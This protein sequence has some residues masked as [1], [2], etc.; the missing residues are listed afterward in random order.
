MEA[1]ILILL[2]IIDPLI[3]LTASVI[4]ALFGGVLSS[5]VM[6]IFELC[7]MLFTGKPPAVKADSSKNDS[8]KADSLQVASA[9]A[10]VG[11]QAP[12]SA[13][14]N[15]RK[16]RWTRWL[17]IGSASVTAVLFVGLLVINQWFLSDLVQWLF[18]RQH[19]RTG[20][21]I[22]TK[23]IDGNLFTGKFTASDIVVKRDHHPAGLIDLS[24]AQVTFSMPVW[25]VFSSV[26]TVDSITVDDVQGKFER[27]IAGQASTRKQKDDSGIAIVDDAEKTSLTVKNENKNRREFQVT[28]L[29]ISNVNVI[30]LDHTRKHPLSIPVTV[31]KLTANPLRSRWAIFDVLFRANANGTIAGR[32]FCIAT[33]GDDLQRSTT[34]TANDLPIALMANHIGG[35]FTLLH[36]GTCD[37]RVT[38]RWQMFNDQRIIVMDWSLILNHVTAAVPESTNKTMALFEKPLV[39]FINAKGDRVPLSFTVSIDENRFDGTASAESAGLWKVVS[40]SLAATFGKKLG[41]EPETIKDLKE[42]AFDKAKDVLEKWRNKRDK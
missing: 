30:Y 24:V 35:P 22:T 4:V 20:I 36:D 7:A 11:E 13:L 3:V 5:F 16:K 39:A 26:I 12:L 10:A 9:V 18:N 28:A 40:D 32:P 37:V 33:T 42:K 29:T 6:F 2:V 19:E 1:L 8:L 31:E 21:A 25:R 23:T 27:G 38:D 34:W 15:P 41:I 14:K 17:L